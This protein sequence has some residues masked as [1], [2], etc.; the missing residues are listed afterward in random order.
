MDKI[1]NKGAK[2]FVFGRDGLRMKDYV[3]FTFKLYHN[4]I[5][6]QRTGSFELL[7]PAREKLIRIDYSLTNPPNEIK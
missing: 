7:N 4:L 5:Q 6:D 2:N 1:D 3:I